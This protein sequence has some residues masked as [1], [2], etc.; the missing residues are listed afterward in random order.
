MQS[1]GLDRGAQAGAQDFAGPYPA[2]VLKRGEDRRL[3]AGHPWVFSNEVDTARSPLGAFAPGDLVTVVG[4]AGRPVGC[5]YVN[6]RTLI[7]ARLLTRDA[8]R[9]IDGA[10]LE[11]RL[12][13]ALALRERLYP[14][15]AYRLVNGE[16]DG[17]PGLVVDRYGEHLV[18]QITT[19]G[20]ER[21]RAA[22]LEAL[23]RLLSPASVLL[24]NDLPARLL[25][26]L[27]TGIEIARG[28][29]PERVT[30]EEDGVGFTVPLADGQKTG[31]FYD[32][33]DNRLALDAGYVAGAR[34]LDVFS[35]VGAWALR[36]ARGGAESV[37]CVEASTV[38]AE[39]LAA[40]A[41]ANEL[42][43]RIT[44]R[45]GDAFAVMRELADAGRRFDVVIL[46]PPAFIKR[47]RDREAGLQGYRN[48][49]RLAVRLLTDDGFLVTA[50]CSGLL[51]RDELRGI[52]RAAALK[53]G[54]ELQ[55]LR[56]GGL[57]ADHPVHPAIPETDYLKC[58]F[59]RVGRG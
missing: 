52:A 59:A 17:L 29:V 11:R 37:T 55:I 27:E 48:L 1:A 54:L 32:Q 38:A 56:Q 25:E 21:M 42:A 40:N 44:V 30:L 34:V 46:D 51:E 18:V 14:A 4:A 53:V 33:R 8:Q 15:P 13:R 58:L 19:A 7:C 49:H 3:R 20:M 43:G 23:A 26:G 50:S 5:G 24:R 9:P 28:V 31:W 45:R 39:L 2:L 47:R 16:G 35:Y 12:A 6:P 36:A 41:A 22:L 10:L 57:P